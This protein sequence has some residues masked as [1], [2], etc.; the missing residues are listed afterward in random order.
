M[1]IVGGGPGGL[2][3][4]VYG[5][6]EGLTTILVEGTALGGQ[7]GTSSR[8]ENYL[9]FPA[10]L[11]GAEL[12]ARAVVQAK[13][14]GAH[15]RLL[16]AAVALTAAGD[17]H[18]VTL[19]DGQTVTARAVVIATGAKYRRLP[20]DRLRDYEGVGVYYAATA[21]EARTCLQREVAIVGGGNSAGQAA[22]YLARSCARVYLIVRR[23]E[24]QATM[25]R[26]LVER[27]ERDPAIELLPSS[28]VR[29]LL[30][31]DSLDGVEVTRDDGRSARLAVRALFLFIG[32][33]PCTDW[34]G[35]QIALDDRGFVL[36]GADV[37]RRWP[38]QAIPL[39]LETSRRGVFCVG[40]ARS[41]SIKRAATAIGEGSM[42]VRLIFDRLQATGQL[43]AAGLS[44]TGS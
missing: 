37:P 17:R 28:Q 26:Y 9:G 39:S 5:A 29:R 38:G 41:G 34:L 15:I 22:L 24:L 40:D 42:V 21:I 19:D 31:D 8:I 23:P 43:G 6:S 11:S 7:A 25:S 1:L 10:G 12:S 44:A 14:F 33:S 4:A 30:G 35:D 2:A 3:A 32:A 13:K 36:T 20:L 27:I 18:V 16:R